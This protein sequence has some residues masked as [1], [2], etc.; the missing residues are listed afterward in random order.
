MAEFVQYLDHVGHK[1]GIGGFE[2]VIGAAVLLMAAIVLI[3]D[4]F[5][6]LR[7]GTSKREINGHLRNPLEW[8][9]DADKTIGCDHRSKVMSPSWDFLHFWHKKT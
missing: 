3:V 9:E 8:M 5:S 4:A 1:L 7:R 6:L 2:G